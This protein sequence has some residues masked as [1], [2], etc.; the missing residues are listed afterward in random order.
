MRKMGIQ[1]SLMALGIF[2]GITVG[3]FAKPA[4]AL[5]RTKQ[6]GS[7]RGT[8]ANTFLNLFTLV[9]EDFEGN[10]IKDTESED[11]FV[12]YFP[13]A[14]TDF[15]SFS[16]EDEDGITFSAFLLSDLPF[17]DET[18][19]SQAI[20]NSPG[21]TPLLS[22]PSLFSFDNLDKLLSQLKSKGVSVTRSGPLDLKAEQLSSSK[23]EYSFIDP[24][25][26][27]TTVFSIGFGLR[28]ALLNPVEFS[29]SELDMFTNKLPPIVSRAGDFGS[30]E[31]GIIT[32]SEKKFTETIPEP[33]SILGLIV[34]STSTLGIIKKQ[35]Q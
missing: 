32:V 27:N 25:D 11:N 28:D 14:V 5:T 4:D 24:S 20:D 3:G 6:I 26:P 9:E 13:A 16:S 7:V 15:I 30:F 18:A 21:G 31:E 12:G 2:I 19:V 10:S 8:D 22:N 29:A 33:G 35:N 17:E 1:R 23:I 34:L